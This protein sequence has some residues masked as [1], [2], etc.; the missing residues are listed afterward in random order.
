MG[1]SNKQSLAQFL[2]G[3]LRIKTKV[4]LVPL[5]DLKRLG[6]TKWEVLGDDPHFLLKGTFYGGW[7][8]IQ[9][10]SNATDMIPL[11]LYWDDGHG[12]REENSLL[13]S[14][15]SLGHRKQYVTLFIPPEARS[16]RLDPGE[17]KLEFEISDLE[18][19]KVNKLHIALKSFQNTSKQHGNSFRAI[20]HMFKR[21]M[22][23]YREYGLKEVW[24]KIKTKS[25]AQQSPEANLIDHNRYQ[26]WTSPSLLPVEEM[27]SKLEQLSYHP[28][29][30]IIVPVYN[31]EEIWLRKCIDSVIAQI[32]PN[33]ELCLVDDCSPKPHIKPILQEYAERDSRIKPVFRAE[34]GHISRASNSG[35]EISTG[36]FIALLDHDDELA[37]NALYENVLLLNR[38]PVADVIYSDE[39]KISVEGERHSPFFKPDWS[40]DT[41]LSQM[42]TSHLTLYRK[43]M[44]EAV[45]GFRVGFEG[46]QDYD[47]M[48]R[49][50]EQTQNIYHIPKIL[51]HWRAIPE[52]TA[53][54]NTS[55]NYTH[56]A[57]LKA[58]KDAI[59]RRGM[60]AYVE[61]V[62]DTANLYRVHY[63]P[64]GNPKVSVI[65]PSKNMTDVVDTC[66]NSI[67]EKTSYSNYEVIIID[68]GSTDVTTHKL[69]EYWLD[70][71]PNRFK[72]YE[73]NIPFNYSKLNNFGCTKAS[74][75]LILFLNNDIEIITPDWMTE[76]VGQVIRPEIGAVG[77]NLLYPDNTIQHAGVIL[78]IGGVAG[79]SH[80][81]FKASDY[82]YFS[83]LKMVSNYSAVTAACL[84]VRK[85]ICEEVGGFDED[86][87]VAF[88]DV[89]FCLK[90]REK[91]YWNVWLPQVQ[92]FHYESKS[93][94]YEDTP[95]KQNRF[96]SEIEL[97]KERW[98]DELIE[99]PFYNSNLTKEHENFSLGNPIER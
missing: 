37:L 11:K 5:T 45:G 2:A 99:D 57:G 36:E 84:M 74:G 60:Q 22:N 79:H 78:G 27:K 15:T 59:Q 58:V 92:L 70:K 46:S 51:Y 47:L 42:Y 1:E 97:M 73:Y 8:N 48:L 87:Q 33:W 62:E 95:E 89:D 35:I 16:L 13:M 80:K 85:D 55:K 25:V 9:W 65:I 20:N 75:E 91:G 61:G 52:S 53:S 83:R 88:N 18:F 39:D 82:G 24:N 44:V 94:G 86:L 77:A 10:E 66:L 29:I 49:I 6:A 38:I 69:Y 40:P 4:E 28:L 7:N 41:L 63:K 64:M 26:L 32:Y 68:N 17:S 50:S 71:E 72:V 93:R 3:M 19:K 12:F 81:H 54:T 14:T 23:V 30:S 98:L 31:V 43:S 34:N 76:M 96:N 67:F 90:V 21:T 56:T